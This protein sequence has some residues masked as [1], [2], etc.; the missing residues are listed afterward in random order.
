[1]NPRSKIVGLVAG[2]LL[3]IALAIGAALSAGGEPAQAPAAAG[4]ALAQDQSHAPPAATRTVLV[5]RS[6]RAAPSQPGGPMNAERLTGAVPSAPTIATVLSDE[7]CQPDADGVS[8]CRNRLRLPGGRELTVRH[9][10]R[11]ADVPCM[12]PGERVRVAP[13]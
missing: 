8:H 3:V 10:H 12:T 2:A 7:D 4:S 1:M 11:M 9:P 13:A 6:G 5:S